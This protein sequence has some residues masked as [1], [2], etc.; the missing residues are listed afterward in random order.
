MTLLPV[1]KFNVTNS[2]LGLV[3]NAKLLPSRERVEVTWTDEFGTDKNAI[4][5]TY[6]IE[7]LLDAGKWVIIEEAV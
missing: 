6:T 2:D 3:Y 1:F 5:A 7:R 4:F